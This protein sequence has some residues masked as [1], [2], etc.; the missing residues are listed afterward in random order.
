MQLSGG[1][2]PVAK[3][4]LHSLPLVGWL[5]HVKITPVAKETSRCRKW[6]LVQ[7]EIA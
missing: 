1:V 2:L 3:G 4:S 6:H 5:E 7:E